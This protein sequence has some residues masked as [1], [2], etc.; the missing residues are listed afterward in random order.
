L[1]P[2]GP[3]V[4]A[5]GG[6]HGLAKSL[7]AIRRYAS[8]VTAVVSVADNG[9][10]S[11]RLR[12]LLGIAAP[13]DLRKC[14]GA[15]LAGPTPLGDALEHRFAAGELAGHAFG[16]L[17]L[18]ALTATTGDLVTAV[19]EAGRLLHAVGVV[20]PATTEPVTLRA[21]AG[22]ASIAGQVT[23]M[24]TSGVTHVSL[25]P[26]TV[27][28]PDAVLAA[29]ERADEIVI[30]PGSLYTSVL[31]ALAAPG[32]AKAVTAAAARRVYVCN[33]REQIPETAGYDVG[34]HVAALIAHGVMPDVVLADTAQM[35]LGEVP[36]RLAVV[37]TPL[38]AA[39]G[40][41]HDELLLASAL[42]RAVHG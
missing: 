36:E 33:L 32:I 17:L 40:A 11:G 2:S 14:L 34:R 1:D 22:T 4:V 38:A 31:A 30:G 15:L 26:P 19:T 27:E 20:L 21:E 5:I 10:S 41:V 24:A 7:W 12:E 23:I 28:P 37:V 13:G 42:R 16:N 6:G 29:I 8:E 39:N 3:R 18:A 25:D 9:G 35:P